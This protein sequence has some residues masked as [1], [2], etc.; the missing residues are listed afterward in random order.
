[1]KADE[2]VG[3]HHLSNG[4]E[5]E[6]APGDGEGQGSLACCSPWGHKESDRTEQLNDN[7]NTLKGYHQLINKF[8]TPHSDL[9]CLVVRTLEMYTFSIFQVHSRITS[10]NRHT[11][12]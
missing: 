3:W 1:M 2:M 4:H 12:Y 11:V 10:C 6:Q 8:V 7:K 9:F 5:S